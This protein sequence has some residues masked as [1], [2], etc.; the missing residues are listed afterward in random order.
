[1]T[2]RHG[3]VRNGKHAAVHAI[4]TKVK[5]TAQNA[6]R[7]QKKAAAAADELKRKQNHGASQ[8]EWIRTKCEGGSSDEE[9]IQQAAK[10]VHQEIV[11]E[12]RE[13]WIKTVDEQQKLMQLAEMKCI[14]KSVEVGDFF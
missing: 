11:D 14:K 8:F 9:D 3:T 1:M 10:T 6:R 13:Y 12:K 2:G 4:G 7:K 5:N